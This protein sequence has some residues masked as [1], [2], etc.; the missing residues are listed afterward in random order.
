MSITTSPREVTI[1]NAAQEFVNNW[2]RSSRR[3]PFNEAVT[4]EE[5]KRFAGTDATGPERAAFRRTANAIRVGYG[6]AT[7]NPK[8]LLEITRR[9]LRD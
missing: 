6:H 3:R 4:D 2:L 8:P 9:V 1:L 7:S 5:L